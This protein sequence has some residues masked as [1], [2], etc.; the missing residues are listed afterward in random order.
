MEKCVS[1]QKLSKAASLFGAEGL[2][3]HADALLQKANILHNMM[4]GAKSIVERCRT[5]DQHA[6]ALAKGIGDRARAGDKRAQMSAW[7]IEEY[8]KQNPAPGSQQHPAQA[9]A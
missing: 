7:L 4:H 3:F 5:G 8:T 1:P 6:M 2:P 9:A